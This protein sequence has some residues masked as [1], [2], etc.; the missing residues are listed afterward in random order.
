MCTSGDASEQ[1]I[2]CR[3]QSKKII[4]MF[5]CMA[6]DTASVMEGVKSLTFRQNDQ[7][8]LLEDQKTETTNLITS[9]VNEQT[10]NTESLVNDL[11]ID[12]GHMKMEQNTEMDSIKS[13]S[14]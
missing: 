10:T 12:I 13:L 14:R 5:E 6:R 2:Q 11:N 9:L 8:S 3:R 4:D 7:N 1:N